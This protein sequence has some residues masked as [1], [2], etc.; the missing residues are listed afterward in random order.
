MLGL[1]NDSQLTLTGAVSFESLQEA[2]GPD[3]LG[4]LVVKNV[5]SEFAELRRHLLSYS[6]YLGNLPA[7]ELGKCA[8]LGEHCLG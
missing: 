1:A 4:I 3:S 6:S 5:P 2:F 7:S 8:L